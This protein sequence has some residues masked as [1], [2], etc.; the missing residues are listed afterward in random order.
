[1]QI[2]ARE[3]TDDFG[4]CG[5]GRS[6]T[7]KCIGWHGLTQEQFVQRKEQYEAGQVDLAGNEIK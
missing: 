2:R 4:K 6:P 7:G 3:N 1:M 5:C